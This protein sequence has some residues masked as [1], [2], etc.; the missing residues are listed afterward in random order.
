VSFTVSMGIS[1]YSPCD[2]VINDVLER[3]D[4]ALY[5]AKTHGRN[6][7]YVYEEIDCCE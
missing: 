5:H 6:C 4:A 2:K 7:V 3:A 1:Q